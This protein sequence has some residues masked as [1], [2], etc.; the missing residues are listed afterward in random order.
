MIMEQ[1]NFLS[2]VRH[3]KISPSLALEQA[4]LETEA[5]SHLSLY[6]L[7][8]ENTPAGWSGKTSL[9]SCHRTEDGIL[10]HSSEAWLNAG[11]GSPTG[12]LML[13]I[14][15]SHSSAEGSSLSAILET[16]DLPQRYFLSAKACRGILRRAT[17]NG[18][19]LPAKL[20]ALLQ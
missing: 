16:G 6:V 13:N 14:S 10:A 20:L 18:K 5:T 9:V 2:A 15:E 12:F 11:M 3:V 1:L 4:L 19:V 7:L 8:K 17:K